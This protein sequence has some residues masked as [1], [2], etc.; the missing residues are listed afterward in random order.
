MRLSSFAWAPAALALWLAACGG[1]AFST[2]PGVD[3][4]GTTGSGSGGSSGGSSSGSSSGAASDGGVTPDGPGAAESG[5]AETGATE[6]GAIEGG[7]AEGGPATGGVTC[8]PSTECSG[9]TPVCCL[10]QATTPTCAHLEC[11]CATQLECASDLDCTATLTPRCCI[12]KVTDATCASGHEV[13]RCAAACL[14]GAQQ[15]CDPNAQKLQCTAGTQCSTSGG[16]LSNVNL[17][18]DGL[19]GVCN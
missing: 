14:N 3:D 10:G 15:L 18:N 19:Y 6:G 8:G 13:A 2:A 9:T 1:S 4:G 7:V 11:G 17:P 5:A 12:N 16:D